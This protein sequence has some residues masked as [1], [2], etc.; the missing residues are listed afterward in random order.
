MELANTQVM[1][2]ILITALIGLVTYLHCRGKR[3]DADTN[4]EY[5]LAGGGLS[6]VFVAGSITLTDV[7][8][9][10][11][12]GNNGAQ[13]LLVAWWEIAGFIGLLILCFLF[14]PVYYKYGCTTTPELLERRYGKRSIRTVI[15]T[16]FL[17]GNVFLSL[18]L[19][20]YG[21]S[22]FM[23][24]L[25][26]ADISILTYATLFAIVGGAYAIFGGLRAV[27]VSD[28]YSGVLLVSMALAVTFFSLNAIDFDLSGV[29]AERMTLIGDKDSPIPWPTLLTGMVFI[30][31]YYWSTNQVVTQRA[32]ASPTVQEAQ[33]GVFAAACIRLMLIPMM[34]LPGIAAFKLYGDVGDLAYGRVAG[35]LLPVW[36]SGA[37]AAAIAAAVL[38]S[39][40][41]ALNSAAALYVVD[42]HENYVKKDFKVS[43]LSAIVSLIFVGI[44]I[45]MV[46]FYNNPENSLIE[47]IQKLFGLMSMPVLSTF[48]VGLLFKNVEAKAVIAALIFGI[49]LYGF[50]T[51]VHAPFDLHYIHLMFITLVSSVLMALSVNKFVF[52]NKAVW[53]AKSVFGKGPLIA[54]D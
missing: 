6:W 34:V 43:R 30:Q 44:A 4:K 37:F 10:N 14:L 7:G 35:D 23:Q 36:L 12:V 54:S 41:S 17:I 42:I 31:M 1:V 38:T 49:S 25:F 27:A 19:T 33:K 16:V 47:T 32:M 50:F 8:A 29:P 39:F 5:F 51:F 2:F 11:L 53:D 22:L 28:T 48:I 18:P 46:P 40:N 13:M 3:T 15:S 24:S 9:G 52:K 21:G 26:G 20:I 45:A